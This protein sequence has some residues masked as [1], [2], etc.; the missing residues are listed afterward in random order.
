[1]DKSRALADKVNRLLEMF[2]AVAFIG[3]RQCGKSTLVR[4]LRADGRYYD[5][6]SPADYQLI[7]DDPGAFFSLNLQQIIIDEAQQYPQLFNVLRG[8]LIP[9]ESGKAVFC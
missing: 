4:H 2:T 1:M 8:L 9:I 7:S 6:E 3:P 5:L